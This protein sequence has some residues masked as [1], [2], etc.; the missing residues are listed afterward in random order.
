MKNIKMDGTDF[1]GGS[2]QI[3]FSGELSI[4]S[5]FHH[6]PFSVVRQFIQRIH[7]TTLYIH[8]YVHTY[9]HAE[10]SHCITWRANILPKYGYESNKPVT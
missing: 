3:I 1:Y 9:M 6:S 8:T 2:N 4:L 10:S 7:S 5:V